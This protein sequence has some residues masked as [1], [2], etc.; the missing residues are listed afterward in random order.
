MVLPACSEE[1]GNG[2]EIR[3]DKEE[4][5][6]EK[7]EGRTHYFIIYHTCVFVRILI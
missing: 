5:G 2:K 3:R 4:G 7:R 6:D 1:A